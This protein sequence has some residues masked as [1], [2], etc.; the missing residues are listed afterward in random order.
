VRWPA[1][2]ALVLAL[3]ATAAGCSTGEIKIDQK[4]AE[5]LAKKIADSGQVRVKSVSC[6]AD[7]KAK[8]GADFECDIVYADGQK[9]TITMHQLDDKGRIRTAGTDIHLA[10]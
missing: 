2:A 9:A 3:A 4:K 6:P 1:T 8:K 10:K 5:D 7:L